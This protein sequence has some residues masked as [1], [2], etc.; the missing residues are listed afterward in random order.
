MC[1]SW[2]YPSPVRL[3]VP[4]AS[5]TSFLR[6]RENHCPPGSL[7]L[8]RLLEASL[9]LLDELIDAE[10]RRPL[11]RWILVERGEEWADDGGRRDEYA[12][13]VRHE[14]VPMVLLCAHHSL[15]CL[16]THL[17]PTWLIEV[18]TGSAWRAAGR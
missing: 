11:T 2:H 17:N 13:S 14:P 12:C 4:C 3:R 16:T 10:A 7:P 8:M 9:H 1:L 5:K 15:R 18:S 6:S